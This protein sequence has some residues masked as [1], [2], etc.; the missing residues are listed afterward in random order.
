[1]TQQGV[2]E[3]IGYR[4][5]RAGSIGSRRWPERDVLDPVIGERCSRVDRETLIGVGAVIG[6]ARQ[7]DSTA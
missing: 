7:C 3:E 5:A 2:A 1:M 6:G 4:P